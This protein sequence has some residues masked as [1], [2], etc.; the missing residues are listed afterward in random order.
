MLKQGKLRYVD[1]IQT[2][3]LAETKSVEQNQVVCRPFVCGWIDCG[4]HGELIR[5]T[6]QLQAKYVSHA[7]LHQSYLSDYWQREREFTALREVEHCCGYHK[8]IISTETGN[9]RKRDRRTKSGDAGEYLLLHSWRNFIS[10]K[11]RWGGKLQKLP[12]WS[13][14]LRRNLMSKRNVPLFWP[15]NYFEMLPADRQLTPFRLRIS[16]SKIRHSYVFRIAWIMTVSMQLGS[17]NDNLWGM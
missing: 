12:A 11:H 6:K 10:G 14:N 15:A 2:K 17:L 4:Q 1:T 3:N 16:N 13:L 5:M 9:A 8:I 7:L